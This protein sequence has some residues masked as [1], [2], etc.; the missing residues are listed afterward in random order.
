MSSS[1]SSSST[2]SSTEEREL[3]LISK[4]SLRLA[5]AQTPAQLQPLLT[6]YLAPLLLKLASGHASVRQKTR[7]ACLSV[8]RVLRGEPGTSVQLPLPR[9]LGQFREFSSSS[10]S[11]AGGGECQDLRDE[12]RR[13]DLVF[14]AVGLGRWRAQGGGKEEEAV[15]EERELVGSLLA[16]PRPLPQ[17]LSTSTSDGAGETM[18]TTGSV[19]AYGGGGGGGGVQV[20]I[21]EELMT[22]D[23]RLYIQ[24]FYFLLRILPKWAASFPERGSKEDLELKTTL[25]LSPRETSFLARWLSKLLLADSQAFATPKKLTN[26]DS[27]TDAETEIL[28]A[29]PGLTAAERSIFATWAATKRE[30]TKS[31]AEFEALITQTKIAVA[32]FLFTAVFADEERFLPAVIMGADDTNLGLFRVADT[33]FKQCDF[34]LESERAVEELFELYFGRGGGAVNMN[35]GVDGEKMEVVA[36]TDKQQRQ[37][38]VMETQRSL[39]AKPKLRIRI[40]GLLA[41]SKR[42]TMNTQAIVKMI[43]Q[44]FVDKVTDFGL[45]ATKLR[46]ALFNFLNWASRV[47]SEV[48]VLAIAPQALEGYREYIMHQGWPNPDEVTGKPLSRPELEMRGNAYESIGI[49]AA[50]MHVAPD[51]DP[52]GIGQEVAKMQLVSFLFTSLRCDASSPGIQVSIESALGRVLNRLS[53]LMDESMTSELR[54]LLTNQINTEVGDVNNEDGYKTVR[55]TKFAAVRFANRCLPFS[56]CQARWMD[57]LAIGAGSVGQRQELVEEGTKGLD[58]YWRSALNGLQ[59]TV[60]ALTFPIFE[61]LVEYFFGGA[62][63]EKMI[64]EPQQE[65]RFALPHAVAF[66]RNV[67]VREALLSAGLPVSAESDWEK[68]LDALVAT[69][70]NVRS[71][72]RN[73]LRKAVWSPLMTLLDAAL[74]GMSLDLGRCPEF[75]TEIGSLVPDHV[76]GGMLDRV[77]IIKPTSV[78]NNLAIQLPAARLLGIF[79]SHPDYTKLDRD[80]FIRGALTKIHGWRDAVGQDVN[81]IRGH[82]L[83]V[84]FILSRQAMRRTLPTE[85]DIISEFV[86]L[87]LELIVEARDVALRNAAH[88]SLGQL[89]L[90]LSRTTLTQLD[91]QPESVMEQ[92]LKDSKKEQESAVVALGRFIRGIS[93][94]QKLSGTTQQAL[95]NLYTLHEIKRPELQFAI[96]EALSIAAAGWHSKATIAEFDLDIARPAQSVDEFMLEQMLDKIIDDCKNTKPSLKKASAIWLLCLIQYVG[97]EKCVKSRLRQCQA[98]FA[99]LLSSKDEIVQETGSRGLGLVYEMG[100]KNLKDD[101]VRDLVASFTGSN[102]KLGGTVTSET[103]LFDAGALP[104]GDGS[105]TTYKDIVSLAAE[106]GDPSLVYRFMNLASN[107]AIW[108]SRSAFGRFGLGNVLADSAYLA[109]NKSFYP[110]LYRYR[111]DPNPNVQKSMND[112]WNALVKD[113]N[114]VIEQ[115]FGLIIEDLLKSIVTGKEWRVRQAS[116]AAIADIIQGRDVEKYEQYLSEIW[117]KAFMVLDDI[118]ETVRVAAMNLCRTLTNLLIRNLEVGE[119]ATKRAQKMLDN[120]MPFLLRQLESGAAKEV[121]EYAIKTLLKVIKK[122]PPKALQPYAPIIV[123]SLIKS[124]TSLEPEA[125]NYVHMNVEKYGLTTEK[126]DSLRVS[127]VSSSPAIQAIERCLESLDEQGMPEAMKRLEASFRTVIGLPSKVGLSSVLVTLTVQHDIKFRPY[128]DRFAQQL[129]KH[130]FDRNETITNSYCLAL[131]Y[132][133]RI[134]TLKEVEETSRFVKNLYFASDETGHRHVAGEI[135]HA[136]S[137]VAPVRFMTFASVFLPFA[138]IGRHDIDVQAREPFRKAWEENVGGSRAVSLYF[139]DI[140]ALAQNIDSPKWDIKHTIA[141]AIAN[142]IVSLDSAVDGNYTPQQAAA[143]WPLLEKALGGKTWD[144][145]EAVVDAFPKFFKKAQTLW[146]STGDH[147]EKVALR[148]AK[149]TNPAYRSHSITA[150]GEIAQIRESLELAE[151]VLTAMEDIVKEW[152]ETSKDRMEIDAGE[153]TLD[154]EAKSDASLDQILSAVIACCFKAVPVPNGEGAQSDTLRMLITILERSLPIGSRLSY[155]ATYEGIKTFFAKF[156]ESSLHQEN[157]MVVRGAMTITADARRV[158]SIK[159]LAAL[160]LPVSPNDGQRRLPRYLP[161]NS[162]TEAVRMARAQALLAYASCPFP[163]VQEKERTSMA[164]AA[165]LDNERSG[166]VRDVL[167]KAHASLSKQKEDRP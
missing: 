138:F 116:C 23:T 162:S 132:M 18:T 149:R 9:L 57:L 165:W 154:S 78:S 7:E 88:I 11:S 84:T 80:E 55:S 14:I 114:A 130:L 155:M 41:K 117:T 21:R 145:K 2:T 142:L 15:R 102:A 95:K 34:D 120:A 42:A 109:E 107:N 159:D 87:V 150:L 141:S 163:D 43:D 65:Y 73:H 24:G 75:A 121:Q 47:A 128:A 118:K 160:L 83:C 3:S 56:D 4:L 60:D 135:V 44:Q 8:A 22:L 131:A 35:G 110:K 100:D 13:F 136:V 161:E 52:P 167:H 115:N 89:M 103:E 140:I 48:D 112:I 67:L 127:G 143:I 86:K 157:N 6:A 98:A 72:V 61:E 133:M 71:T 33:M 69:D 32:K 96:G 113:S 105:V 101:L 53:T 19:E 79:M 147:V 74:I 126:L 90:C 119:G 166:P 124:L 38:E 152:S 26:Q 66:C 1:F 54:T 27:N 64:R 97:D 39:P 104:T 108:T 85:E 158:K 45:E 51:L 106:M 77:T 144:G 5:L 62:N 137:K 37:V 82:L 50:R 156:T 146:E 93:G 92:L 122:S 94:D 31:A 20:R 12:V 164:V 99:S 16:L 58:P 25:N 81:R 76:I 91:L 29:L 28:P 151:K 139:M 46:T 134:A 49:W 129:R 70:D 10:S 17:S 63:G 125:I 30:S 59:T 68:K 36:D 153:A 123:E 111:F 40:L 148:E